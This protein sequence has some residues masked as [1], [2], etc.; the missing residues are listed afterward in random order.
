MPA[1]DKPAAPRRR[2]RVVISHDGL[3]V[4]EAWEDEMGPWIEARI[5]AGYIEEVATDAGPA[6]EGGAV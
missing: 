5:A 6:G 2:F 3:N 4:G 1:K